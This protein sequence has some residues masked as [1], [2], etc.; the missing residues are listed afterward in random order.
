MFSGVSV[1]ILLFFLIFLFWK[2]NKKYFDNAEC[3]IDNDSEVYKAFENWICFWR[4]I[5]FSMK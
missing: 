3:N 4:V 1:I 2:T 5:L